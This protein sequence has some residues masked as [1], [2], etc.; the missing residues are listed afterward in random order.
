MTCAR[1]RSDSP[2]Q[3]RSIQDYVP[4]GERH[5]SQ[6]NRVIAHSRSRHRYSTSTVTTTFPHLR[7]KDV[8]PCG[9]SSELSRLFAPR[10]CAKQ[11]FSLY[12]YVVSVRI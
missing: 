8:M 6:G 9:K 10:H 12:D 11:L 1:H 5:V 4:I 7:S 3:P 2:I